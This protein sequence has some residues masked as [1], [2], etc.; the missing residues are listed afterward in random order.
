MNP[1]TPEASAALSLLS[2]HAVRTRAQRMLTL[3]LDDKLPNFR[4]DLTRM[5][6]VINLVLDTTR[7]SYPSLDVPFHSRWRHFVNAGDDRW[8]DV[9]GG[10]SWPDRAARGRAEFDLAIASVFLDAGAGPT[11]RYTDPQT[12]AAIGRSEGLGLAS[13]AM[14]AGGTF[15]ADPA[16]PLRAD[17]S[18]L[19][20][21]D[22][23]DLKRGMQVSDTNPMV[24]IDGRADL[25][26]RLGEHV[27]SKPDVFGIRD[28]PRPGGLFD[29]L[30]SLADNGR[31]PAPTILSELL[32]QLGPIWPSRLTLDGIAL[33]DCWKHPAMTTSDATS[34]LVPLHKL[35]QWLAYSL[36]EPLQT[37]G[38][39]VTD[40][41]GLT[42][43][44]EYRNGGLFVDGGV[45]KFRDPAD[46][47]R[48]HD[49]S[50]PLVVEWR[51]L[52]VALL[53]RVAGGLRQRLKLDA[54]SLPLAKVLE[55]GTW[56]AGRILARER[57]EDHSPPV[58]V[59]SDG[60]V[61]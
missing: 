10:I 34:G 5:D 6:D 44:A 57:R 40:I 31:L 27:A 61:F 24:G 59:I 25:L 52:T 53:D 3:G 14:F 49:V 42:G 23:S 38:I 41:D 13:L 50:S 33:G 28:R 8:A 55:G 37:A 1:Q 9:A 7:A 29:R 32:L 2:A 58:K 48:E 19:A 46:A 47:T 43:L 17:A 22:V 18:K 54:T 60:T 45:L 4:I 11:W 56:V 20:Q 39:D 35:S 36:I 30:A 12:G 16:Q 21:L 51:A 26:R 15:S